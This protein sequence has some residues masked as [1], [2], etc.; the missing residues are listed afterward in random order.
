METINGKS[1]R[2]LLLSNYERM[3]Q[4]R[5][6][7]LGHCREINTLFMPRTGKFFEQLPNHR[8]GT[9]NSGIYDGTATR[10][11]RTTAA[12]LQSTTSSPARPWF[13][14]STGEREIDNDHSVRLWLDEVRN[15]ILEE[16]QESNV[17]QSLHQLYL[18]LVL[19][20]T[21]AALLSDDL[22]EGLRMSPLTFGE[23]CID[24]AP[25]GRVD[26]LY[27]E[28]S[29]TTG[30]MVK[31]FGIDKCSHV[32]QAQFRNQERHTWHKILHVIEPND[33]YD[34]TIEDPEQKKWRSVY[35]EI[36][37]GDTHESV[38]SE[39]GFDR[40]PAL[41]VRWEVQGAD[42]YGVSPA[43][44]CL[45]DV[46]SLQQTQLR[47]HQSFDYMTK[48]PMAL[49]TAMRGKEVSL[50]PGA[51]NYVPGNTP[52]QPMWQ[53]N[54]SIAEVHEVIRSLHD[55]IHSA[56][57]VD[58][59]LSLLSSS[60]TTQRTAEEIRERRDEKFQLLGPVSDRLSDECHEPLVQ[61]AF[62][63][64]L[65]EGEFPPIP[66]ALSGSSL[67][68]EFISVLAQAQKA[69]QTV[70]TDRILGTV[71][72]LA[73]AGRIEVWDK[74]NIPALID[75]LFDRYG[76]DPKL[77]VSNEEATAI[78]KARDRANAAKEQMLLAEQASK[79]AKNVGDTAQALTPVSGDQA[80]AQ[81]SGGLGADT[82]Y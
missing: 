63:T 16:F 73:N 32:V 70:S 82:G 18:E 23:Y 11:A 37:V 41:V 29:M 72:A 65:E 14:I 79:A 25:S 36:A 1:P 7:V 71:M 75:H 44:D 78:A 13:R 12:S 81:F 22:E 19:Y 61:F 42:V 51:K 76:G 47:L 38:L 17:Y 9:K 8:A 49:P 46:Q 43:M 77:L 2:Q 24:A 64:L 15:K 21:G 40:F 26:T 48:P 80:I 60:D 53:P 31:R 39:G 55:R 30:Q 69:I 10:A 57:F 6:P 52:A 4:E 35:V 5:F 33:A 67:K 56:L 50:L 54:L 34:P 3:K 68:I 66:D 28:I 20:G 45:G 62:H 58:V 74:I 27:R 59:F